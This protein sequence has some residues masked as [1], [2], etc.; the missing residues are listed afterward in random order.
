LKIH[1][2]RRESVTP[3]AIYIARCDEQPDSF[4]H[5]LDLA[6]LLLYREREYR[7]MYSSGWLFRRLKPAPAPDSPFQPYDLTA[8]AAGHLTDAMVDAL[9]SPLSPNDLFGLKR[10]VLDGLRRTLRTVKAHAFGWLVAARL[11]GDLLEET[12]ATAAEARAADLGETL[13][14]DLEVPGSMWKG[15]QA[16]EERVRKRALRARTAV[17]GDAFTRFLTTEGAFC[18]QERADALAGFDEAKVPAA[19]RA[20]VP[21]AR[22]LGLGDDVC[23]GWFIQR[24]PRRARLEASRM[25]AEHAVAIDAWLATCDQPHEGEAA[26]FFW[27]REAGEEL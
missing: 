23:R 5:W 1:L 7:S 4:D 6:V 22:R 11:H 17:E 12:E 19:L 15:I 21:L 13:T 2:L 14:N 18:E 3:I 10:S 27:L 26:A 9:A 25:I 20:L 16:F 8:E 24:M